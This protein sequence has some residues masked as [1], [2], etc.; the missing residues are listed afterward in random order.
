MQRARME[1]QASSATGYTYSSGSPSY[2]HY[3][4]AA[5]G[6]AETDVPYAFDHLPSYEYHHLPVVDS[7][8]HY[9]PKV[10]ED[11]HYNNYGHPS[12]EKVIEL[13]RI[14][15]GF[16]K[17]WNFGES[18]G[19]KHEKENHQSQGEKGDKGFKKLLGWD[20]ANKGFVDKENHKGWYGVGGGNKKGHHDQEEHWQAK[21]AE[22][23]GE[24]GEK[25]KEAKGHK[26]GAK[27]S[28]Y[29]KVYLKDEFKKDHEF[30]D[31]ADR[32]GHFNKYNNFDANHS[33]DQGGYEKGGHEQHGY[34]ANDHGKNGFYDKGKH[35]D[36]DRGHKAE[37]GGANF[38]KNYEEFVKKAGQAGGSKYEYNDG[39]GA[40]WKF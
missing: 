25:F 24:K 18:E 32:K 38:H 5:G 34:Q 11:S 31:H 7:S 39:N 23:K 33:K 14:K 40:K 20:K 10:H 21:A 16:N 13:N 28:G 8:M 12:A 17:P 37:Q 26:K 9:V 19:S 22:G 4:D 3:A 1:D 36:A 35:E 15:Y 29:H 2:M 27:T 30:Y 6:V